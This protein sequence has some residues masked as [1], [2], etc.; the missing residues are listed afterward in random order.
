V[1]VAA[2]HPILFVA[3][4]VAVGLIVGALAALTADIVNRRVA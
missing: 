2:C 4:G 3:C 1:T